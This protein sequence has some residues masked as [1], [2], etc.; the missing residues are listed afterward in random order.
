MGRKKGKQGGGDGAV[1]SG[2]GTPNGHEMLGVGD[3]GMTTGGMSRSAASWDTGG[4][5]GG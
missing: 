1:V 5:T 4:G 2:V 3:Q